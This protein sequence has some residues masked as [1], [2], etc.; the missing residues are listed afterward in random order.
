MQARLLIATATLAALGVTTAAAGAGT[1][2]L[3]LSA[4]QGYA[5]AHGV[6]STT[7][8]GPAPALRGATPRATCAPGSLPETGR[9]GR[10]PLAEFVSGRAAK[11]YTCNTRQV[12]HYGET[13]GFQVHR[14]VDRTGRECAFYDSTLLFPKD[15]RK[16]VLGMTVLDMSDPA[17]PIRTAVLPT[18]AMQTTHESLRVNHARGLLV[19]NA[20]SPA[21]Q[22]G[23][24]DVY[25][26]SQDCRFPVLKSTSPLGILG[27][28]GGF[29]PDGRTYWVNTTSQ[30]GMTAIDLTDPTQPRIV[31]RTTD[32]TVHGMSF[33]ADGNRAYLADM[34]SGD[35]PSGMRILDVSQV[36]RRV[37]NPV[38]KQVSFLTWP[39][40]SIPQNVLPVT[41][42]GKKHVI[43]FD[44]F[45]SNPLVYSADSN[46]GA[47]RIIDIS[48]ER[49]PKVVSRIRLEVHERAARQGD[50]QGDP[51]ATFGVQ[52][53]AAHYCSVPREVEPGILACSMILSGLRLFDVRDPAKPKEVAYFNKPN[54]DN[55]VPLERGAH[56]MSAPAFAPERGEVWYSDGNSGF[57]NVKV[58]PRVWSPKGAYPQR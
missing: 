50:Q 4:L 40:V 23:I 43:E 51:Q 53:Y 5:Q 7:A 26:V 12:G 49:R 19:A 20:G 22:V 9:Q 10:V 8:A 18:F 44:E 3:D 16:G 24:V 2:P 47:A 32:Y 34:G 31:F 35:G 57:F 13:G 48:D 38:V 46:V 56:A 15:V 11:G 45:D 54:T 27:H 14:Y 55:L 41:I 37:P 42:K 17:H 36:Q 29:T 52:G 25:D 33:S 21:T 30:A 39:E 58:S 6:T 28:E 1:G